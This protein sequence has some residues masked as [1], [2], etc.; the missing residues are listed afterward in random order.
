MKRPWFKVTVARY[1]A[2]PSLRQSGT[3]YR[4][5]FEAAAARCENAFG[6]DRRTQTRGRAIKMIDGYQGT[7]AVE[8]RL[9]YA[10]NICATGELRTAEW[11]A[12]DLDNAEWRFTVSK[13][14]TEHIVPL[15]TQAVASLNHCIRSLVAGNT[16]SRARHP[17]RPMSDNAVLAALR[18]M[19]IKKDEMSGHGFR[20]MARTIL[21]EELGFRTDI[22]EH[23]L[24]HTVRDP[25]G[26]AY[27]RT[28]HLEERKRMMQEWA[29]HLDDLRS[30]DA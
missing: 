21:D 15:A 9:S 5:T 26:R 14:Q 20:A 6:C 1:I 3:Q 19:E 27:N 10:T 22:I 30:S 18:R 16:F 4:L 28:T 23:Q 13:T 25:L 11:D 24:A 12:I 17:R 29:D 2:T 7:P 8:P